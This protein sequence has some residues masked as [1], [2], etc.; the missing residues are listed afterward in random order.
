MKELSDTWMDL[1]SATNKVYVVQTSVDVV[2]RCI[3]MTSDPGDLILD[4]T[5]GSGTTAIAAE[6]YGRRWISIDTSR[7]ANSL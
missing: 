1:G 7:V 2:K 4:P 3:L 5:S 6:L